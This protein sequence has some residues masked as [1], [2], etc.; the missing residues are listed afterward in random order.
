MAVEDVARAFNVP[1]HLLGLPGTNSYASVEQT[2][3]AWLAH[4]LRPIIEKIETAMTPLMTRSPGGENAYIKFNTNALV[5]TD[6][7]A[8][9]AA[10]SV[11]LQAGYLSINDVRRL[12]D[13][14]PIDDPAA[15]NV[16]VPLANVNVDAADLVAEEKRV[17]IAQTLVLAGFDPAEALVVAGLEPMRHTGVPS[18]QLQNVA[19]INPADPESVYEV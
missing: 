14:R 11:G 2:N 10:Y 19:N 1:P 17:K 9:S 6:L 8:R 18:V 4:G 16:R 5:R 3:L 7:A 15:E 12:E 13:L